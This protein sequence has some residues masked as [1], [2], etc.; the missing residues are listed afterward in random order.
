[1]ADVLDCIGNTPLQELEI[2]H[3]G[4]NW[5]VFAKLEFLNPSGSVKDRIAR[6]I[7]I[8]ARRRGELRDGMS[9]I[10]AT[11]GNTGIALSMVGAVLGHKVIVVMPEHMSRERVRIMESLGAEVCLT[12][13]G[14]SFA[15]AVEK[16]N[17]LAQGHPTFYRPRQFENPDNVAAHFETTG[18]EIWE[19]SEGEVDALVLSQ[20][21][22][23]T[24]TGA[25]R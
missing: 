18:P 4:D 2:P 20:G 14:G 21:T 15:G 16:V 8:N 19:Q 23:G 3:Q 13:R 22:G 6:H 9:I 25:G 24:L 5:R 11:S 1:M 7:L 12:S 17:E 10:E